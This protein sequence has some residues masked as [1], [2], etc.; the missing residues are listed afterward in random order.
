MS[1]MFTNRGDMT[2]R[3]IA[4]TR[5]SL[6]NLGL[7]GSPQTVAA[8]MGELMEEVG[9]DGFL[10]YLPTTRM[11]IAEIADGLA[12]V[13]QRRGSIRK[14]YDYETLKENLLAF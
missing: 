1:D 7:V 8:K 6:T 2:L 4:A 13:L 10:F 9:G 5:F 12:P 14:G 3:E 11:Q